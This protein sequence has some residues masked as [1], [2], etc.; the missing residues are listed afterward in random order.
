MSTVTDSFCDETTVDGLG[1]AAFSPAMIP[2]CVAWF[3]ADAA[4]EAPGG[5]VASWT[6][7][8]VSTGE[9]VWPVL[10]QSDVARRPATV[11]NVANGRAVV[12]ASVVEQSLVS[13]TPAWGTLTGYTVIGVIRAASTGPL[14]V[15]QQMGGN[16]TAT[17][18]QWLVMN[19]AI[20]LNGIDA[21]GNSLTHGWFPFNDQSAFHVVEEVFDG[22]LSA[23]V[24]AKAYVD[25]VDVMLR[26]QGSVPSF[27]APSNGISIGQYRAGTTQGFLGQVAMLAFYRRALTTVE[28]ALLRARLG[29]RFDIP[30][31]P[32]RS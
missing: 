24:R 12:Q 20:A 1:G 28:R 31:S 14:Q 15:V 29:M 23:S 13:M 7:R 26:D 19:G 22:S 32:L 11:P 3:D 6:T 8:A 4:V 25:G 30:V 17:V 16:T 18:R 5:T 2:G 27:H 10:A 9:T 21:G